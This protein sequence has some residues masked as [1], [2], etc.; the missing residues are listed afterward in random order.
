MKFSIITVVYNASATIERTVSSVL[1]QKNV[2]IEYIVIDGGSTDGT[3]DFL[4]ANKKLFDVFISEPD[5]GIYDAM[6]KGIGF[7]TGDIIG[8][9]NADDLYENDEVLSRVLDIFSTRGVQAVYGDVVYFNSESPNK[10]IRHYRSKF[11]SP[12]YLQFG[13][14]PAHPTLFLKKNIYQQYGVFDPKF[15]IAGD[16]ELI[17]RVFSLNKIFYEYIPATLVRMQLGGISNKNSNSYIIINREIYQACKMNNIETNKLKLMVRY[18]LKI[19]ELM[20]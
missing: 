8:F 4:K 13:L 12:K 3:T 7:A 11:F 15:K 10:V 17:A 5:Q 1:S 16:F 18:L 9:L 6:N 19:T 2:D 14:M 20:H